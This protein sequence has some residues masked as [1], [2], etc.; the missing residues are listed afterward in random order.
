MNRVWQV[1]ER[2]FVPSPPEEVYRAVAD[3]RRMS[4][5]SPE[6][7]GVWTRTAAQA[8]IGTRFVGWNRHGGWLWFT[9]CRVEVADE[10]QEF[11]FT[12]RS[13]TFPIARW[14]YRFEPTDGGTM[15]T[16]YW[17]DTR[18]GRLRGRIAEL[19]GLLFTGTIPWHRAERNRAGM[20]TTLE[21]IST[22]FVPG[23]ASLPTH[24][25][26][27]DQEKP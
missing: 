23:D 1:S 24:V 7:V 6:C 13:F 9:N 14:G 3:P 25:P 22:S 11:A 10:A 27:S 16:E 2:Q 5:W 20:R 12:V 18:R 26:G 17:E 4:D 15:L 21:R 19:L 8:T